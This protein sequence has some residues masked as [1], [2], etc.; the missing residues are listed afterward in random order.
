MAESEAIYRIGFEQLGHVPFGSPLDMLKIAP[1]LL[2]LGAW[3]TVY[4]HV[5]ARVKDPQASAWR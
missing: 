5:A 1:D 2:R 4:Q 3:R